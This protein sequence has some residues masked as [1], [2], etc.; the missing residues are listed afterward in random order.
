MSKR[1]KRERYRNHDSRRWLK[2]HP[3]RYSSPYRDMPPPDVWMEPAKRAVQL[4]PLRCQERKRLTEAPAYWVGRHGVSAECVATRELPGRAQ[5]Q[6][7]AVAAALRDITREADGQARRKLCKAV[8][9]DHTLGV[10]TAAR[11]AGIS[12]TT[13]RRWIM[14]FYRTVALHLGYGKAVENGH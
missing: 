3:P 1:A 9:L 8:C 12:E 7:D 4:W 10:V 11:D 14:R 13:A 5:R 2:H 6:Y